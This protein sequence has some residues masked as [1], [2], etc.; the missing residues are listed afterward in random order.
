LIYKERKL[1]PSSNE[2][3]RDNKVGKT[4]FSSFKRPRINK[5]FIWDDLTIKK[6]G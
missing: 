1:L 4:V 6:A 2:M 3:I 5:D